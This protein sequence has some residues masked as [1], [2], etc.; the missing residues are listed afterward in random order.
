MAKERRRSLSLGGQ[1]ARG[2]YDRLHSDAKLKEVRGVPWLLLSLLLSL[3]GCGSVQNTA[4]PFCLLVTDL[5]ANP[6]PNRPQEKISKSEA[7]VAEKELE[8]C[9]FAPAIPPKLPTPSSPVPP[10]T[11]GSTIATKKM[12]VAPR[13]VRPP[14]RAPAPFLFSLNLHLVINRPFTH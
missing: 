3:C 10:T 5:P 7:A 2:L 6:H 14:P 9:T 8:G 1:E 12:P 13:Y 4:G 11:P